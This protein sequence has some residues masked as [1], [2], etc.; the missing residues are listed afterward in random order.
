[1]QPETFKELLTDELMDLYDAEKQ[2]VTALPKMAMAAKNPELK[3]AFEKHLNETKTHVQR[4]E[5]VFGKLG[6]KPQSKT[7][8]AMKGLVS[9]GEDIIAA[10]GDPQV[11]DAALIGGAQKVENYEMAAYVSAQVFAELAGQQEIVQILQSTLDEERACDELLSSLA[12]STINLQAS[13]GSQGMSQ[14]M[15]MNQPYQ[16]FSSPM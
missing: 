14:S 6:Q 1:M 4:L 8:Q 13:H 16:P 5:A 10:Q 3:A 2:L 12:E 7:C 9:E 15:M 11:K